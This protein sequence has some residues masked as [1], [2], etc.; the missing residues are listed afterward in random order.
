MIPISTLLLLLGLALSPFYVF[1]SGVPQP[2]NLF[3]VLFFVV[4]LAR[5]FSMQKRLALPRF[6]LVWLVLVLWITCVAVAWA[7]IDRDWSLAFP[8]LFYIFNFLVGLALIFTIRRD[9][10]AVNILAFGVL[11]GLA[12]SFV[13]VLIDLGYGDR[14]TGWFNNPNQLGYFSLLSMG[15]LAILAGFRL[16]SYVVVLG[17]VLGLVGLLS[18]ASLGAWGGAVFIALAYLVA[19]VGNVSFYVRGVIALLVIC[20]VMWAVDYARDGAII[21]NMETRIARAPSKL[22]GVFEERRYDR[23]FAFKQYW[24]LGAG[25]SHGSEARFGE[26]TGAEVHSS[27]GN[28][29]LSYGVGPFLLFLGMLGYLFIRAPLAVG[30]VLLGVM[31]YSL[32]HMGL[33][34]TYFWILIAVVWSLHAAPR[35]R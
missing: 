4:V 13:G 3:F 12:F 17:M 8:A 21:D 33:R 20:S 30:F 10:R 2:A 29:L 28:L 22:D 18:S 23:V 31:F 26:H 15:I 35:A 14:M 6:A 32:T 34:S 9:Q 7:L 5:N 19:N 24:L 16:R 1:R 25:E 11:V 27:F